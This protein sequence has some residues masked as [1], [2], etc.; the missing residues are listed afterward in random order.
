MSL[1]PLGT[2]IV[3]LAVAAVLGGT[4]LR[5]F[6]GLL[7]WVGALG[8]ANGGRPAG[9]LLVGIG[10]GLWLLGRLHRCLRLG[11]LTFPT[12]GHAPAQR[13]SPRTGVRPT[14]R[15]VPT[16]DRKA[17]IRALLGRALWC[18]RGRGGTG[19]A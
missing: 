10:V 19:P 12:G 6:G 11:V 7:F 3:V 15:D 9:L 8:L 17:D 14:K 16:T 2:I 18:R 13:P 1:A 5:L 4:L